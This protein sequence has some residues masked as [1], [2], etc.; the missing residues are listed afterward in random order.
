MRVSGWICIGLFALGMLIQ[1]LLGSIDNA[2]MTYPWGVIMGVAYIY[3]LIL[4]WFGR[5]KAGMSALWNERACVVSLTSVLA[6]CLVF[7]LIRQESAEVVSW[8]GFSD[9]QRNWSF[10]LLLLN[11][12][13]LIGLRLLENCS[14]LLK[15]W[16]WRQV[17]DTASHLG[18]FV[19]LLVGIFGSADKFRIS[20]SMVHDPLWWLA[21][22][23]LWL[24]LAVGALI[25]LTS[26]FDMLRVKRGKLPVGVVA[27]L[28]FAA[29]AF[30]FVPSFRRSSEI[31]ALQSSW[32]VP[33]VCAYICAYTLMALASLLAIWLWCTEKRRYSSSRCVGN[34]TESASN[35]GFYGVGA[36]MRALEELIRLGWGFLTM[37]L[38]MGALWA[39][40][41]WGD[42]WMWDPKETW[43]LVTWFAYLLILYLR[44]RKDSYTLYALTL[45]AFLLLQMC[46]YGINY[47][48][49]AQGASVHLYR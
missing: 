41:A 24:M 46:W 18:L 19:L 20:A 31:P 32:F 35:M 14:K 16:S 38:A 21:G 30:V 25:V 48:P 1:A 40:E 7:G 11:F 49:A 10:N 45:F 44:G 13:S 36:G 22:A 5:K 17:C 33:H 27:L 37:G 6:M 3:V 23:A 39:K 4:V 15:D 34:D 29:V 8:P 9:M 2:F 47:L 43:A 26:R 42:Y 28:V 12:C